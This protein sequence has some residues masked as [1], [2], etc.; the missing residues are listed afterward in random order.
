[1]EDQ[2]WN[3]ELAKNAGR[4]EKAGKAE[5]GLNKASDRGRDDNRRND[6]HDR[7]KQ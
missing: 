3:R 1:M 6:I 4:N 5:S 7:D 2:E